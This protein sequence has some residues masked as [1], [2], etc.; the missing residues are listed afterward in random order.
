MNEIDGRMRYIVQ[1]DMSDRDRIDT[2]RTQVR[3][4]DNFCICEQPFTTSGSGSRHNRLPP[5]LA[6]FLHLRPLRA[7]KTRQRLRLPCRIRIS[8]ERKSID[9][10]FD[11]V[12]RHLL[13]LFALVYENEDAFRFYGFFALCR[14]VVGV[15]FADLPDCVGAGEHFV[16]AVGVLVYVYD[17][18]LD[19][20]GDGVQVG[21]YETGHVG[22]AFGKVFV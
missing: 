1:D 22:E 2:P 8:M 20:A 15:G 5:L 6:L 10:L 13:R 11:E 3:S 14:V 9:A 21:G 18:E 16:A 7:R 4:N 17:A 12:I 19:A